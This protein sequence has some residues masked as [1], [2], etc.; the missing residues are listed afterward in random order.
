MVENPSFTPDIVLGMPDVDQPQLPLA[1][2]GVQRWV[3]SS[4]F[5][6]M[7]IEVIGRDV[8]VNGQRVEPHVS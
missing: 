6:E 3:W 2:A 4:K 1:S 5:G 7:L 8:F